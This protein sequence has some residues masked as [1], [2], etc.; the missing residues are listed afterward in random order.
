MVFNVILI[1][2]FDF[3]FV[4]SGC[5]CFFKCFGCYESVCYIR[6]VIGDSNDIVFVFAGCWSCLSLCWCSFCDFVF[7]F[8]FCDW[9]LEVN[10]EC[11]G[12]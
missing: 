6:W 1:L 10:D 12:E 11:S 5:V 8:F 2:C 3:D 7:Y 9:F 4:V